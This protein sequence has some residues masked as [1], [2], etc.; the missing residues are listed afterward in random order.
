[1]KTMM[2]VLG[3]LEWTLMRIC[4]EKGK[5][6]AKVIHEELIIKRKAKYQ[7]VKT[8]MDR[9]VTKGYLEREKFG[10]IWL[11]TPIVSEKDLTSKAIEKFS[12]TVLG[13]TIAPIFIHLLKKKEYKHEV[14]ELKRLINE[15]AEEE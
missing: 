13:K 4:W 10:P 11:Y 2:G 9:L 7:T 14:E 12:Q 5:S 3:E 15:I 8:T 6:S 1:M